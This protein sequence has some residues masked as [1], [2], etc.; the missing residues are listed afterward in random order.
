MGEEKKCTN[1]FMRKRGKSWV[2]GCSILA[3]SLMMAGPI[4]EV[5][6]EESTQIT[7]S[8]I[9]ENEVPVAPAVVEQEVFTP[10]ASEPENVDAESIVETP[11]ADVPVAETADVPAVLAADQATLEAGEQSEANAPVVQDIITEA[12]QEC[13]SDVGVV[14]SEKVE[15]ENEESVTDE[16]KVE[17]TEVVVFALGEETSEEVLVPAL[18]GE[19]SADKEVTKDN[20]ASGYQTNLKDLSYDERI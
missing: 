12:N 17:S 7:S 9:V 16:N 13:T 5:K 18:S 11:V 2:Y 10:A 15:I 1:W 14:V 19:E 3:I 4:G 6:A 8:E 20:L